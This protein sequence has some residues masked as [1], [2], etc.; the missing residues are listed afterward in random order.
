[1][2]RLV[3]IAVIF[4]LAHHSYSQCYPDRH[5]S[6]WFDGWISCEI[7][8]N[9]NT[10]RDSTHWIMYSFGALY[11]MNTFEIWNVNAPELLDY[12]IKTAAIDYSVD[13]IEWHTFDTVSV[14]QGIGE[15]E[16][17]G[18]QLLDFN[19]AEARFLLITALESYGSNCAGFAEMRLAVDSVK[20][21]DPDIVDG[22]EPFP[23]I[24]DPTDTTVTENDSICITADVYPNPM[25]DDKLFITL[26][27]QCVH[28][29]NYSLTDATG[30]VI[31]NNTPIGVGETIEILDG[32]KLSTG[33]YFIKLS[34]NY[35][36]TKYKV[37]KY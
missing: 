20:V 19:G 22:G 25:V 2:K 14:A 16:Y 6:A 36:A 9:P 26:K 12:G 27:T 29:V 34:S 32:T 24:P 23:V 17:E 33:V 21:K 4:L 8:P 18:Q 10:D 31:I 15:N 37:V 28:S 11:E 1:M 30:R 13:G 5:N 35:A 7:S 3:L